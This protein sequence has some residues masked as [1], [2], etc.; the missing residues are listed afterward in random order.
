MKSTRAHVISAAIIA[1]FAL[2]SAKDAAAADFYAGKN[3]QIVIGAAAGGGYDLAGRVVARHIEQQMPGKPVVV[4]KNMAGAS[5]LLM[6]NYLYNAAPRD[7][8]VIGMPTNTAPFEPLERLASRNGKNIHFDARKLQWIGSPTRE[9]YVAFVWHTAPVTSVNDLKTH[10][11]L[12]GST[13]PGGTN[14]MLPVL[15]NAFLG[16]TMKVITGYGSQR[17]IF[18]AL[19]RGEVGGNV[20]GLTNLTVNKADWLKEKKARIVIQYALLKDRQI[21]D[22]PSILDLIKD[23]DDRA[24]MRFML[25]KFQMARPFV[26]PQAVSADR[27]KILRRAFDDTMKAKAFLEDAGKLGLDINPISGM[28]ITALI[29]KIYKTPKAIVE[30]TRK[31]ILDARAQTSDAQRGKKRK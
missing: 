23:K 4:V 16:T 21:P 10:V 2:A 29:D 7:G 30:R 12:M 20:T 8:T 14:T 13:A 15:T 19:E 25:A 26:A 11:V 9:T 24:A 3:L 22:V 27:I 31:I 18:V 5:G 17:N 1:T 6:M 28:E